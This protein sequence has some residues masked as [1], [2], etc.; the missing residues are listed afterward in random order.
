MIRL[1]IEI[2]R[3][4]GPAIASHQ[5]EKFVEESLNRFL[6]EIKAS[7]GTHKGFAGFCETAR[8][9]ANIQYLCQAGIDEREA[10]P[11]GTFGL[12]GYNGK[13]I[14]CSPPQSRKNQTAKS[15]KHLHAQQ[16]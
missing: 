2:T 12:S 13:P 5:V 8:G 16:L 11:D 9:K 4:A 15:N 7:L 3:P 14:D 1:K 10:Y 6:S